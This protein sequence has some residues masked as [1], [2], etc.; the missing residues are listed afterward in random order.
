MAKGG[1]RIGA[2]RKPSDRPFVPQVID[3][4]GLSSPPPDLPEGQREFW[5]RNAQRAVDQGTLT[6]ETQEAFR[7]LCE[8]EAERRATLATLDEHGRVYQKAWVDQSGQ[9][10]HELKVHPLA[11]HYRQVAK[12]VENLLGR[13]KLAP[14]GKPEAGPVKRKAPV[15][16]PWAAVAGR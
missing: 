16:N 8:L 12:Q 9:E 4:A 15:A 11:T 3:G 7:L 1:A 6:Q 10:H 5:R 14:F 13:F 2:G